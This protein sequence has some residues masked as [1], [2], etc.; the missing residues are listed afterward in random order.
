LGIFAPKS[1]PVLVFKFYAV[2]L[3]RSA[4]RRQKA[5]S[6]PDKAGFRMT[7]LKGQKNAVIPN[8]FS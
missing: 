2:P 1:A 3:L 7:S 6:S 5:G 8:G 4:I